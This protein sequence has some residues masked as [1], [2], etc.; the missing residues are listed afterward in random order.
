MRRAFR[1][2]TMSLFVCEMAFPAAPWTPG[3]MLTLDWMA[4]GAMRSGIGAVGWDDRRRFGGGVG[5][6]D[7]VKFSGTWFS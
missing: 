7:V 2:A 6:L 5:G 1:F 4:E 3:R